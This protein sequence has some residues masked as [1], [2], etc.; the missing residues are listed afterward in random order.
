MGLPYLWDYDLGEEQFRAIL[1]GE[2]TIDRLDSDWA[3]V[4]LLEYA[5]YAEILRLLG[6]KRIIEG[7]PRWREK[8]RSES[9]RR[10]FDFLIEWE[11]RHFPELTK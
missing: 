2:R 10:G 1:D 4:R 9:R 3:A 6:F 5:S 7:W 8:I 11:P